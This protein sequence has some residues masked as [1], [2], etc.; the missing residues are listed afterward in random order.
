MLVVEDEK[1]FAIGGRV[2]GGCSST[3]EQLND[4]AGKWKESK[5]MNE[6]RKWFSAVPCD[7]FMLCNWWI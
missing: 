3:M 1:L 5:S 4:L 2:E 7:N 6:K